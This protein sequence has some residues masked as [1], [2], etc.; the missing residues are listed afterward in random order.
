MMSEACLGQSTSVNWTLSNPCHGRWLGTATEK[1]ENLVEM[2]EE[3]EYG[4]EGRY[5]CSQAIGKMASNFPMIK[6]YMSW[7]IALSPSSS[8]YQIT[9]RDIFPVPAHG[10]NCLV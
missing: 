8:G 2:R 9:A 3:R 5:P 7:H 1:E 10:S 6:L 4:R